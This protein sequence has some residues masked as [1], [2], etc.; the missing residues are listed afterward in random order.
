LRKQVTSL[1][2]SHDLILS[3]DI[4]T[5]AAK[6]VLFDADSKQVSIVR[7]HYP[8]HTPNTGWSE[9]EP[10]VILNAV[11]EAMRA[12]VASCPRQARILAVSFSS[13]LY[14]ILAIG[15]DGKPL[16]NSLTWSDTRSAASAQALSQ[17]PQVRGI[18]HR[19][20]CPIDAIYPLAKIG[21]LKNN[22]ELPAATR[23]VSIKEYV[24]F[25]LLG[26]WVVDWSI[27]SATG[28]FDIRQHTWDAAALRLVGVRPANLSE[29]APP[30]QL[31]TTWDRAML[32][33]VGL[34][35]GTPL[36]IG[37]G[38]GP[39]AS[40]GVG[41]YSPGTLAVNVGTS[42]AAR[43]LTR[44]AEVDPQG[45]LWTYVVDEDLWVIGGIVSSGGMV[46]NWF[47]R[48]FFSQLAPQ[49]SDET[50][51]LDRPAEHLH[52]YVEGLAAEI[53]PGAENLIFMPYL[54]GEQCPAW[55]PHTRGSFFGLDMRH[56]PGHFA[57]AVLEGITRSIYRIAESLGALL[58]AEF[59]EVRVTGG[60]A[61]SSLW[62][63]I[64]ADMFGASMIV[65][66]D[67]EGSARGAAMLALVSLG[68]KS[69]VED[70]ADLV[71]LRE[72]VAPRQET[73]V[74]YQ[75]QYLAFQ[76]LLECARGIH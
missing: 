18:V 27:A 75:N 33:W 76:Q 22:F 24:I 20:G 19:T 48:N 39:L 68:L 57:R 74:A 35:S 15:P 70:F 3:V 13:Q 34:P 62:L 54:A 60:L 46:Y 50:D 32:D 53:A 31:F 66:E 28:L 45:R 29:L 23:F 12:V 43:C 8:I 51:P 65:P 6:A 21:W 10:E 61:S 58:E 30:R 73:H 69:K 72:Q 14:S 16:T 67:T 1:A 42:A 26:Q 38:D 41:A 37:A 47:L 7:K 49:P 25:R 17:H 71:A 40:L 11:L 55:D 59:T 36:M 4:G 64:A 5:S 2:T 44:E 52:A 56:T 9:Q 63:Q